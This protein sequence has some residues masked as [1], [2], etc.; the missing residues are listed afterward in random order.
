MLLPSESVPLRLFITLPGKSLTL[1]P[2]VPGQ[3]DAPRNAVAC[4]P[5]QICLAGALLKY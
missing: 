3:F 4:L 5:G 1:W 2:H